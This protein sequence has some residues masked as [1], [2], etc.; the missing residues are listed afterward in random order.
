MYSQADQDKFPTRFSFGE[1]VENAV[2]SGYVKAK[3]EYWACALEN[4]ADG[5]EHFHLSLK[6]SGPRRWVAVKDKIN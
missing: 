6:L 2:N 1:A 5:G 4:H 3:V